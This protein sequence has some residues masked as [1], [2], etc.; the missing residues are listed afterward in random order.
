MIGVETIHV[1]Q[2]IAIM[3]TFSRRYNTYFH[4]LSS[5]LIPIGRSPFISSSANLTTNTHLAALEYDT[6]FKTNYLFVGIGLIAF[7]AIFLALYMWEKRKGGE[8]WSSR[9]Y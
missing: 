1:F 7:T 3:Q 9:I 2:E 5:Y 4:H 6:D 8:K